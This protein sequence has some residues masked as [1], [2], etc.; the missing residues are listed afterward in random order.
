LRSLSTSGAKF[1]A[2]YTKPATQNRVHVQLHLM[3]TQEP[4]YKPQLERR[5]SS[6][7]DAV[8]Q[9]PS[10]PGLSKA[11][12]SGQDISKP[13]AG[14]Q[15]GLQQLHTAAA[16]V[17]PALHSAACGPF[18]HPCCTLATHSTHYTCPSRRRQQLPDRWHALP[19]MCCRHILFMPYLQRTHC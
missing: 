19:C 6:S 5:T 1:T 16:A 14:H 8:I 18:S 15:A 10:I 2:V 3:G 9:T 12:R 11:S 7:I 4:A 17:V 13:A